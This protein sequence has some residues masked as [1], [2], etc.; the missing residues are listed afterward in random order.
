MF[1][2]LRRADRVLE[3]ITDELCNI[4]L[5]GITLVIV[6]SVIMRYVFAQPP[7]W[8]D[9]VSMFGNVGMI[10]I[11]L[12]LTVRSRES[13]AMRVL[14]EKVSPKVSA[15]LDI[16]WNSMILWF[17]LIFTWNGWQAAMQVPGFYWEL[18]MLPQRYPMMI[19]PVSGVLLIIAVSRV[20]VSDVLKILETGTPERAG[21]QNRT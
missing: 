6:Y 18:N 12:S 1:E 11:A 21:D 5:L 8:S 16:V 4:L 20:L 7:F 15:V 13:I 10:L 19:L 14:Y 2:F 3:A 17:A 9:I